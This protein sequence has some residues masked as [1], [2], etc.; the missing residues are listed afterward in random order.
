M[1][2]RERERKFQAARGTVDSR[3]S[4][5]KKCQIPDLYLGNN[6]A[7]LCSATA[8]DK[9]LFSDHHLLY[10]RSKFYCTSVAG[11]IIIRCTYKHNIFL[12]LLLPGLLRGGF[13]RLLSC[14]PSPPPISLSGTSG[15][16]GGGRA[17]V[18]RA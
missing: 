11:I 9:L 2:G 15:I 3:Y 1:G 5:K 7:P 4:S 6:L 16:G 14:L 17:E 18:K 8:V 12:L 10:C 13:C